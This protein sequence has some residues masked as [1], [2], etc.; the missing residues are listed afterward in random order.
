MQEVFIPRSIL[1]EKCFAYIVIRNSC[2]SLTKWYVTCSSILAEKYKQSKTLQRF[3]HKLGGQR[4]MS[5]MNYE[6]YIYVSQIC[7]SLT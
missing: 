4:S 7:L 6:P 3:T 2:I 5:V 1:L